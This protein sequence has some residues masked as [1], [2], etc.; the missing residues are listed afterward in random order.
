[1]EDRVTRANP[2]Q[3]LADFSSVLCSLPV[4]SVGVFNDVRIVVPENPTVPKI[5]NI[6]WRESELARRSRH[7]LLTSV[8]Q[9]G[10]L[11]ISKQSCL[12]EAVDAARSAA[13]AHRVFL[14][15][16]GGFTVTGWNSA[17]AE[18]TG[19]GCEMVWSGIVE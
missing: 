9:D 14:L 11:C 2:G 4:G 8:K 15:D 13:G 5:E 1:M 7:F 18:V 19:G 17:G 6:F 16:G 3:T 12:S 10:S